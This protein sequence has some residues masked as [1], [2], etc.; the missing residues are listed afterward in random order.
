MVRDINK[1]IE[2]YQS[3]GL[4]M[5]QRW[6][7]NY[8]MLSAE[9]ITVG[10]HP[11]AGDTIATHQVSIGFMIDSAAAG[12]DLLEKNEIDY[13]EQDD[14]DSGILLNFQDPDG[15]FLYFMEPRW[16]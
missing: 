3:I 16:K 9:G 8:A 15:T 13:S 12:R 11:G 6:G 10:L 1:S 5:K 14:A 7:D 4:T 2:F